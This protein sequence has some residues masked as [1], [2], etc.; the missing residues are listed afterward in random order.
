MTN[1]MLTSSIQQNNI[2]SWKSKGRLG[3]VLY[4]VSNKRFFFPYYAV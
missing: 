2:M 3:F 4:S 1:N